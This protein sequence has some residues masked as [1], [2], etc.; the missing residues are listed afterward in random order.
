MFG[1]RVL[2]FDIDCFGFSFRF[3]FVALVLQQQQLLCCKY[4]GVLNNSEKKAATNWAAEAVTVRT[5]AA[6]SPFEHVS[7]KRVSV[8]MSVRESNAGSQTDVLLLWRLGF[9][10]LLFMAG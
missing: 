8:S 2:R 3:L 9:L 10:L 4:N 5:L 7:E 6:L 1:E